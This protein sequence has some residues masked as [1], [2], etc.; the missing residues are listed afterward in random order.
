MAGQFL[1]DFQGYGNNAALMLNGKYAEVNAAG[2]VQDPDP[3]VGVG[4]YALTGA[5]GPVRRVLSAA[6]TTV[7]VAFRI[8]IS[9]LLGET[10]MFQFYDVNV[11]PHIFITHDASGYVKAYRQDTAGRVLLGTSANPVIVANAWQHLEAKVFIN[12]ATGTVEV[13]REGV[14]V[15]T[16]GPVRTSTD[17]VGSAASIQ[18]YVIFNRG[19]YG[20]PMANGYYVKDFAIW[21]G[22]GAR[23]NNFLGSRVVKRLRPNGDVVFPWTPSTGVTGYNRVNVNAP[24]DDTSYIYAPDPAPAA[25]RFT[26]EDL[27]VTVTSVAFVQAEHRSRKTDGGDG[28]IQLGLKSS[29]TTGLGA[30]RPITTAYT[31]YSDIFDSDPN[32]GGAWS[33]AAVNALEYQ[34]NRTL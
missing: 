20:Q 25:S 12:A 6:Q 11:L 2:L 14:V 7:G 29:A 15:L 28:N 33:V 24:T 4:I 17:L 19:G 13:R 34:I 3:T 31:Y 8:W 30:D 21:D 16:V 5:N 27:A 18:N 32:G 1:D 26:L 23:N 10:C 9:Q 22:T